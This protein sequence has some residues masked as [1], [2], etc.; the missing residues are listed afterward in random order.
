[1]MT[2]MKYCRNSSP[3]L[4]IGLVNNMSVSVKSSAIHQFNELLNATGWDVKLIPFTMRSDQKGLNSELPID[5][6]TDYVLDAVIV[7]GMEATTADLRDEWMWHR[8]TRFYDWCEEMSMPALWSC[9]A[10]HA[11]VLYHHGIVRQPLSV[12]LSG[13]FECQRVGASNHLLEGLPDSWQCP[14]SRR[15]GLC[16]DALAA[17]GYNLLSQGDAVGVDIFVRHDN[18]AS[19]YFQGHPEYRAQTLLHEFFRDLRRYLVG[20][21]GVCP[22]VPTFYLDSMTEERLLSLRRRVLAGE[23]IMPI[24]SIAPINFRYDWNHVAIRLLANWLNIVAEHG[25][26]KLTG[27]ND[28][29]ENQERVR[30]SYDR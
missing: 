1:M 22:S 20:Q 30:F 28:K 14:H 16:G 2:V 17:N 18:A 27:Q 24:T 21:S 23:D 3:P 7:T 6:I 19:I 26:K 13:V 4:V 8:F 9:L 10:A 12:K 11:A 15:N 29:L 5:A 25:N